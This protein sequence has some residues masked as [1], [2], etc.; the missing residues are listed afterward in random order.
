[1]DSLFVMASLRLAL[2][3]LGALVLVALGVRLLVKEDL[4]ESMFSRPGRGFDMPP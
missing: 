3:G 4:G 2:E 1:M